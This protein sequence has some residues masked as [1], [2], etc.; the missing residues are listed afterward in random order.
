ML[1]ENDL[2]CPIILRLNFYG[3]INSIVFAV[4]IYLIRLGLPVVLEPLS[5]FSAISLTVI[6]LLLPDFL[7]SSKWLNSFLFLSSSAWT[8]LCLLFFVALGFISPLF[9]LYII[10][11]IALI[12]IFYWIK[13]FMKVISL[14]TIFIGVVFSLYFSVLFF[15]NSDSLD[16]LIFESIVTGV[17]HVDNLFRS[18]LTA[19]IYT[20]NSPSTG[21]H[22]IPL[23]HYHWG[24]S[25]ILS[26]L[27]KLL[28]VNSLVIN[29]ILYPIIFIP[30]FIK[31][32]G[33]FVKLLGIRLF[34]PVSSY[35]SSNLFIV[36]WM[37]FIAH[38]LLTPW[39]FSD[40]SLILILFVINH[41]LTVK[42]EISYPES[43]LW[44][45]FI[46]SLILFL[47]L[48]MVKISTGLL[49]L[50]GVLWIIFKSKTPLFTRLFY[51]FLISSIAFLIIYYFIQ[52]R[53]VISINTFTLKSLFNYFIKI[54][55]NFLPSSGGFIGYSICIILY[56][57][58]LL[59]KNTSLFKQVIEY[60]TTF[61]IFVILTVTNIAAIFFA[62]YS[63]IAPWGKANVMNF[64]NITTF[65]GLSILM[66]IF[67]KIL[68]YLP[69]NRIYLTLIVLL[70]LSIITTRQYVSTDRDEWRDFKTFKTIRSSYFEKKLNNDLLFQFIEQFRYQSF[71]PGNDSVVM[72]IPDSETWY[73]DS[74]I[75]RPLGTAFISQ[76][77]TG[78]A[79][80]GGYTDNL[81]NTGI[82]VYS[83]SAYRDNLGKVSN[84]SEAIVE[85]K[86]LGF[87]TLI[88]VT[89]VNKLIKIQKIKL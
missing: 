65:I 24:G 48:V 28:Q 36:I 76:S 61:Q 34:K 5:Y 18:S 16:P 26:N 4:L 6:L 54:Y 81:H 52:D 73:H 59:F 60:K 20:Y 30:L 33:I 15:S 42:E 78:I 7:A 12:L 38:G 79:R 23:I 9:S 3:I 8:L 57:C 80:I 39:S 45:F 84:L 35:V 2:N 47:L 85:A 49:F 87:N 53:A 83:L 82:K 64:F 88:S 31:Q 27:S 56:I 14:L 44:V 66:V 89:A 46:I 70:V 71:N 19:M 1:L 86:R 68:T 11:G 77:Y 51:N 41:V 63:S 22:G 32:F 10:I 69:K 75:F 50:I 43:R 58:L 74:Q 29:N 37:L 17:A 55:A 40:I 13:Y 25:F 21:I 62:L 67:I 72:W